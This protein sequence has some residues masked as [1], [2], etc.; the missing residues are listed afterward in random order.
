MGL[1][2]GEYE[3]LGFRIFW[4]SGYSVVLELKD[5]SMSYLIAIW[6]KKACRVL[7]F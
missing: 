7:G 4:R 3:D 2:I 1:E 6:L 5:G